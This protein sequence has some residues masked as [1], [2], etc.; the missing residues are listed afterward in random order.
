MFAICEFISNNLVTWWNFTFP[1]ISE[2]KEVKFRPWFL[3]ESTI[4][5]RFRSHSNY[6][7]DQEH[8][9]IKFLVCEI[10]T[11]FVQIVYD[12]H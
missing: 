5:C 8:M 7:A 10:N 11:K 12:K 9:R 2:E 6:T 3:I 1:V 4:V